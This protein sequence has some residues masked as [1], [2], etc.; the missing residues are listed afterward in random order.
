MRLADQLSAQRASQDYQKNIGF[1]QFLAK[2]PLEE[3]RA[4]TPLYGTSTSGE[5]SSLGDLTQFGL[6]SYGPWPQLL[7][8]AL[9][10][11][12]VGVGTALAARGK[13]A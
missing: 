10:G 3:A 6:A 11:A 7:Q 9:A 4:L 5:G 1:Q 12:G 13:T 8:G 2:A